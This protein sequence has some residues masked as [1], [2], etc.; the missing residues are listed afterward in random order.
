LRKAV[1]ADVPAIQSLINGYA[2][3]GVMLP[4]SLHAL[5]EHLRDYSVAVEDDRVVGCIALHISWKDLAEVRSLAVAEDR[6]SRRVG[7]T[8][9]TR[10]LEEARDFGLSRVFVLTF[11]PGF[12]GR[13][14]FTAVDKAE[15]P[16]KIWQECVHCVHFPDCGEEALVIDLAAEPALVADPAWRRSP[17]RGA[18]PR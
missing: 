9:V 13:L 6:Q 2:G 14:G 3:K 1:I 12:F 18:D 5:Y 4:R 11:V 16:H 8:L 15:L 7:G 17:R 10:A